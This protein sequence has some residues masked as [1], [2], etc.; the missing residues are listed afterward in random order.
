MIRL[1]WNL[2]HRI[3]EAWRLTLITSA[4][5]CYVIVIMITWFEQ[6]SNFYIQGG[7][8][9]NGNAKS[10]TIMRSN[11][12]DFKLLKSNMM[13]D[14]LT[15]W[16][17]L[18]RH[19]FVNYHQLK[20]TFCTLKQTRTVSKNSVTKIYTLNSRFKY[21]KRRFSVMTRQ[22]MSDFHEVLYNNAKSDNNDGRM[23]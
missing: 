1:W 21:R 16:K 12:N 10:E 22:R 4:M 14:I 7:R 2:V 18:Y 13:D 3:T 15:P 17:S 8:R 20:L 6:N 5:L 23:P 19:I 11:F 9:T